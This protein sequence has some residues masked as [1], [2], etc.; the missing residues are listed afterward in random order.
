MDNLHS[1]IVA[2]FVFFIE[3]FFTLV[4]EH[5]LSKRDYI[6]G[7]TAIYFVEPTDK[8]VSMIVNVYIL[9]KFV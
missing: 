6:P 3:S 2:A 5:I 4:L 7:V 8:N 1:L 9:C